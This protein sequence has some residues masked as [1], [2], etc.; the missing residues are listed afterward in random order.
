MSK[1]IKNRILKK[2]YRKFREPFEWFLIWI[3]LKFIPS[4]SMRGVLRLSKF[5]ADSVYQVDPYGKKISRAN[6]KVMFPSISEKRIRMLIHGSYRNMAR[7]LIMI[8]WMSR[9][10]RARLN[11]WVKCPPII[12]DTLKLHRPAITVS[13]HVG[14]WEILSQ[15]CVAHGLP[16]VS[17][18]KQIGTPEMTERLTALRSTIGQELVPAEGALRGLIK[19]LKQKKYIGL[20]V[21]QH[22]HTWKGGTWVDFFG[23]PAGISNAPAAL[24]IKLKVPIYFAWSHPLKD[25]SYTIRPGAVFLPEGKTAQELTQAM[26]KAF[27]RVI[28]RHPSLWCLNY[29]RWRY[30]KRGFSRPDLYPFYARPEH[31]PPVG[32]AE[33]R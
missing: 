11:R 26:A 23:I 16:I 6:L 5:I 2:V 15:A 9:D 17:V 4:L 31:N 13:A 22:T 19:A 18:A 12:I 21:D 32:H 25:G 28:R 27:E 7:V 29:K 30:I 3:A 33:S 20:L 24:S 8:F 10:T 1:G 14:N